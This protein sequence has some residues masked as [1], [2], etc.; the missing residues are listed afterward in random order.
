MEDPC[1]A[2]RNPKGCIGLCVPEN[3][4]VTDLIAERLI[5]PGTA[6]V[7]FSNSVVYGYNSFLGLPAA[8]EA[9][10]YFF[11]K[12]F[13]LPPGQ[14]V[15]KEEALQNISPENVAFGSGC[16]AI[17]NSLFY[18]LG[19]RGDACLIPAPFHAAFEQYLTLF[20]GCVPVPVKLT[21]PSQ[22][23]SPKELDLA[24]LKAQ[25]QGYRVKFLLLTNPNNP[26]GVI[27]SPEVVRDAVLW[28]RKRALHMVV[29]ELYALSIHQVR[30]ILRLPR[31][32][33]SVLTEMTRIT[34]TSS[35]PWSALLTTS[36]GQ[37]YTWCGHYQKTLDPVV[38]E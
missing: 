24:F 23:P 25:S 36:L 14:S 27:Y 38:S 28:A 29:D 17:I 20:A 5:E 9:L 32:F 31:L 35:N 37:M 4:L 2:D 22:G 8:R 7:A 11:A 10:A 30:I 1:D 12:R 18:I 19:E 13:L 26:L 16:A 6:S 34:Y 15:T 33:L 3:N 21:N